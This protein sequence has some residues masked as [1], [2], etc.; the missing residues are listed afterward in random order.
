M[1]SNPGKLGIDEHIIEQIVGKLDIFFGGN[2]LELAGERIDLIFQQIGGAAGDGCFAIQD[3]PLQLAVERAGGSAVLTTQDPFGL[4][5]RGFIAFA[6]QHIQHRLGS[7]NLR[8]R[9]HQWNKAQ[10]LPHPRDLG[11][12]IGKAIKRILLAQLVLH[13]GEHAA[14]HLGIQNARIDSTQGSLEARIF[15]AHFAEV[16]GNLLQQ[17]QIQPGVPV[18]LLQNSNQRLCRRVAVGHAHR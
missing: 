16:V 6:T 15:L 11:Q 8:S 17:Q 9:R 12:H 3:A 1:Q 5:G 10:I 13:V 18:T 2:T 14:R 4:P 7:D